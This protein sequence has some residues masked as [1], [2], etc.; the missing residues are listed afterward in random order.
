[1]SEVIVLV[2][3]RLVVAAIFASWSGY[4]C[5]KGID[6]WGWMA[7]FALLLGSVTI[8]RGNVKD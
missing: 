1:M 4:L 5:W 2:V 3:G 7:F 6:G 8:E